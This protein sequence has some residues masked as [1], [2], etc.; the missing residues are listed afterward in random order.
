[1]VATGTAASSYGTHYALFPC[2]PEDKLLMTLPVRSE[3]GKASTLPLVV[4]VG[5]TI[6]AATAAVS[7]NAQ[8]KFYRT[9]RINETNR[10]S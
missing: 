9:Y 1:M 5:G 4:P 2:P 3:C 10:R 6:S 7:S 8:A